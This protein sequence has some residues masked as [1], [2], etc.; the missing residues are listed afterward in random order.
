MTNLVVGCYGKLPI[1]GDFIRHNAGLPE[2]AALDRW[3]QEGFVLAQRAVG[4]R[5]DELFDKAPPSR[6]IYYSQQTR[7]LVLG[8]MTPSCDRPG[9]Q[10]P[11]LIFTAAPASLFGAEFSLLPGVFNEFFEAALNVA[12]D[13]V[14]K[15]LRDVIERVENLKLTVDISQGA[16]DFT[17]RLSDR[18]IDGFWKEIF[19]S[20]ADVRRYLLLHNIIEI[21][22]NG[23]VPRY[24]IRLPYTA[25]D[26]EA[27]F[28]LELIHRLL[29]SSAPPTMMTWNW[30]RDEIP[31]YAS[32]L[33][34]DLSPRYFLSLFNPEYDVE[35]VYKPAQHGLSDQARLTS[36]Q[37][38]YEQIIRDP[39]ST[40]PDLVHRLPRI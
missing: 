38:R 1:R 3:I 37:A 39:S 23:N 36:A 6:F 7:R 19:G 34:D 25:S 20:P 16:H 30:L 32:L 12:T 8:V 29:R 27:A 28:W 40:L 14:G 35:H 15:E 18:S 9:R 13:W 33:F 31:P 17:A 22:R 4:N 2:L 24:I 5:W 10:Y 21:L 26:V 11:F